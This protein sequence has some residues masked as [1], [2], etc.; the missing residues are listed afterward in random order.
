VQ[1]LLPC[2]KHLFV[3]AMVAWVHPGLR[4]IGKSED[5]G[6][7]RFEDL[8]FSGRGGAFF[9]RSELTSDVQRRTDIAMTNEAGRT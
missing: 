1:E 8:K 5:G 3:A 9:G 7:V 2:A 6:A 4:P